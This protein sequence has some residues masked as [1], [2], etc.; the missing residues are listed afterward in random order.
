LRT[1]LPC[2]V[3]LPAKQWEEMRPRLPASA[4]ELARHYDLYD[5]ADIVLIANG[6][7]TVA[8]RD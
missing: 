6:D 2:Y 4:H 8:R 3:V 1:P 5:G 7:D